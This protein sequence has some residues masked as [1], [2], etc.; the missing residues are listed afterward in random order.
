MLIDGEAVT[1]IQTKLILAAGLPWK[2]IV[3]G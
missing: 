2:F 3:R 1:L